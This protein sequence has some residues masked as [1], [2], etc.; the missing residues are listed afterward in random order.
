M[1]E[2]H[3]SELKDKAVIYVNSDSNGRGRL[4]ASGSH[5]LERFLN[6]ISRDISDPRANKS[7]QELARQRRT[8][9][10][11][12]DE[13]KKEAK[14]RIDN[15][16]GALGS[17]SDYTAF[18]DHLGVASLNLQFGGDDTGGIYHSIY[19]SFTGIQSFPMEHSNMGELWLR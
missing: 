12:T 1:A 19:D 17:G 10:A 2:Q 6:E 15:R 16:I 11:R 9:S 4:G 8:E 3:A 14:T 5:T 7:V 18:I 13:E